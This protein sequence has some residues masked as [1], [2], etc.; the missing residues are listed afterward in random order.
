MGIWA[1]SDSQPGP[2]PRLDSQ[3]QGATKVAHALSF[4]R[5]RS[6]A[7]LEFLTTL[8]KK[9]GRMPLS[10]MMFWSTSSSEK[11]SSSSSILVWLAR[12]WMSFRG[13]FG[14]GKIP[15]GII[16]EGRKWGVRSVVVEFGVFG[17]PRFS[18][19]R[20]PNTYF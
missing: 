19:Q 14:K 12:S 5:D 6:F 2:R 15:F 9:A 4:S 13:A 8:K 3:P 17:A 11:P 10:T 16:S 1:F 20:F 7:M 18:V